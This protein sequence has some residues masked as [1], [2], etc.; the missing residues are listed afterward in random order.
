MA[1]MIARLARAAA[2]VRLPTRVPTT[3]RLAHTTPRVYS[4]KLFVVR[5]KKKKEKKK[6]EKERKKE[7]KKRLLF[8]FSFRLLTSNLQ[9][10]HRDSPANNAQTEFSFTPETLKVKIRVV[11]IIVP[12]FFFFFWF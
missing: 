8:F 9:P 6:E 2:A 4:D 10:Q 1:A 5:R 7:R 11:R 12:E 3:V